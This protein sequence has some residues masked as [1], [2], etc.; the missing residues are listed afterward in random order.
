LARHD[1][2]QPLLAQCDNAMHSVVRVVISAPTHFLEQL[3]AARA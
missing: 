2:K 1:R 3:L